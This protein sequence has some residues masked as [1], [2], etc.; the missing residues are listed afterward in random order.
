MKRKKCRTTEPIRT[1]KD[2]DAMAEYFL[3][4]NLRDYA[5]Y[6]FGIHTGRRIADILALNVSD[7]FYIDKGG[8]FCVVDLLEL[9]E[10]KTGKLS[11]VDIIKDVKDA[12]SLYLE[13]RRRTTSDTEVMNEPLF[14]S[15]KPR[16][17]DRR[18]YRITRQQVWRI[19]SQAAR[20]CGLNYRVGTHSMRKTY[21][22][23]LYKGNK[24]NVEL[25]Q[26]LLKHSN[27]SI[28]LAYIGITRED[29]R[30]AVRSLK[31][32]SKRK[33]KTRSKKPK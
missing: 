31:L 32:V 29:E 27:S 30:K 23:V 22:Y 1:Q 21:G 15:Q 26:R 12:L 7:V 5:L 6:M 19:L 13:E 28:T 25:V 11:E 24:N 9:Q 2:R 4:H 16:Q 3:E 8:Y 14:K 18:Q 10:S 17:Q 20:V 33:C